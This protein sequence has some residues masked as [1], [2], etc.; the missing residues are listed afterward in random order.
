ME[1]DNRDASN[2][3]IITKNAAYLYASR[4]L[5]DERAPGLAYL[6]LYEL[7][8]YWRI[9]LAAYVVSD[10]DLKQEEEDCYQARLTYEGCGKVAARKYSRGKS[11]VFQPTTDY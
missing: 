9:E 5:R 3:T 2:T 7:F 8:R 1:F 6:S 4:P 10:K 11:I